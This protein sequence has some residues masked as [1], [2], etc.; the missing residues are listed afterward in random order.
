MEQYK[1]DEELIL[2]DLVKL[3]ELPKRIKNLL[4]NDVERM[5]IAE[6]GYERAVKEDTWLERAKL[7]LFYIQQC[8]S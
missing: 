8:E 6:R 7:L 1:D 4:N 5:K 3:D 2:F